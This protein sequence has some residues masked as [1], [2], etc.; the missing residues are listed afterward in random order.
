MRLSTYRPVGIQVEESIVK[1][2]A[3]IDLGGR[4]GEIAATLHAPSKLRTASSCE[5]TV[6]MVLQGVQSATGHR[7]PS[8]SFGVLS[9]APMFA[10]SESASQTDSDM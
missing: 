2:E 8:C 5:R 3:S 4:G 6:V 10:S 1:A 9:R 7:S